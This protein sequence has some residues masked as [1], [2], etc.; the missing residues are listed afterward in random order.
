MAITISIALQKGGVGK[1]AT[2]QAL[3]STI[4]FKKKRALL[5]DLDP[6]RDATYFSGVDESQYTIYDILGGGCTP[7][8]AIV[9]CKYYDLLP[10]SPDLS[11]V[12]MAEDI[13]PTLL[14]KSITVL[15]DSYDYIVIDTAPSLANL[16][17]NALVA[18]DYIVIPSE[19]RPGA[20]RGI[21][22][23]HETIKTIQSSLNP[24]LRVLGI[25]LIKYHNRTV[26]NRDIRKMIEEYAELMDTIVFKATIREGIAV[27]EAQTVREPLIDY[28]PKSKPNM[29][30]RAFTTQVLKI[31]E[32]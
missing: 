24:D 28:A 14:K 13:K 15:K 27:A 11:K 31:L 17:F 18:S 20:L 30:Y 26:L 1:T 16:S 19:V 9:E 23:L 32:E 10:A 3:A 25:L 4:G 5:I 12:E 8:D 2:A 7:E 29:D 22:R 21:Q 6:Q